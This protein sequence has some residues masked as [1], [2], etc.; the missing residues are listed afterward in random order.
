MVQSDFGLCPSCWKETPFISG[1]VCDSCGVPLPGES[2]GDRLEC[3][4]CLKSPRP[5]VDGRS[6]FV[7]GGRARG[8][9]LALKHG[10]R[11][12]IARAAAPWMAR[13]AQSLLRDDMIIAPIPLHWTR[14]WQRR[15]NQSALLARALGDHTN[16][17]VIPDLLQRVRRTTTQDGKSVDERFSNLS[18]AIRVDSRWCDHL[19]GRPI[20]LVDDVLTSGATFSDATRACQEAGSGDVFVLALARAARDDYIGPKP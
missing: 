9:V 1:T 13:T 15:Y 11:P 14:L 19:A 18:Q 4:D 12:E 3:D 2:D 20:L 7:Y 6:V 10:D 17:E 16:T 5:W 8:L